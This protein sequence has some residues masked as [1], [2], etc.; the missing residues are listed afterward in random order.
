M[1]KRIILH[2]NKVYVSIV[3][4]ITFVLRI[5]GELFPWYLPYAVGL[6]LLF[7]IINGYFNSSIGKNG[8]LG[9]TIFLLGIMPYVIGIAYTIILQ[10]MNLLTIDTKLRAISISVQMLYFIFLSIVIICCFNGE[11]IDLIGNAMIITY[12]VVIIIAIFNV[13]WSG[14]AKYVS[15]VF[16]TETAL[17]HWF[18]KHDIGLSV[19]LII[20]YE[21]FIKESNDRSSIRIILFL[22]VSLLCFKKIAIFSCVATGIIWIITNKRKSRFKIPI[23]IIMIAVGVASMTYVMLISSGLLVPFAKRFGI[24]FSGRMGFYRYMR[25]FYDWSISFMGN[26]MGFTEKYMQST[27]R[28]IGGYSAVHNDI[29]K[30]YIDLGFVGSLLWV[31]WFIVVIP[32]MLLQKFGEKARYVYCIGT[33]YA[34][35]VYTTDNA[36]EYYIFQFTLFSLIIYGCLLEKK[37]DTIEKTNSF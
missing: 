1:S 9:S 7:P 31:F 12:I 19:G 5:Y 21:I 36:S 24:D 3:L 28:K 34:Y 6:V 17:N 11:G 15:H 26:G 27:S 22:L 32:R 10:Y 30:N 20:I 18:E 2:K 16:F 14:L 23:N 4:S 13:G 33:I 8:R 29:L 25:K 35:I 37:G